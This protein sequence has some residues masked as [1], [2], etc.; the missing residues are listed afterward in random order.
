MIKSFFL[1][2]FFSFLRM[3]TK[4]NFNVKVFLLLSIFKSFILRN[5]DEL[6][7]QLSN[8]CRSHVDEGGFLKLKIIFTCRNSS[9]MTDNNSKKIPIGLISLFS[10]Q[11]Y[12]GIKSKEFNQGTTIDKKYRVHIQQKLTSRNR[13]QKVGI[14]TRDSTESLHKSF[15]CTHHFQHKVYICGSNLQKI[16]NLYT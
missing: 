16:D 9:I 6:K 4:H 14:D 5:S 12:K 13:Y 3:R 10:K 7:W 15:S 11:Y 2:F 8:Y 1:I